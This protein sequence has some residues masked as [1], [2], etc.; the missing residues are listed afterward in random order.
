MNSARYAAI[1]VL[2]WRW[3]RIEA[4]MQGRGFVI[5]RLKWAGLAGAVTP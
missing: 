2:V 5:C 3:L 4:W 1:A